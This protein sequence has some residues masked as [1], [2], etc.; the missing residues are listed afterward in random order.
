[1]NHVVD[2]KTSDAQMNDGTEN[3][4]SPAAGAQRAPSAADQAVIDAFSGD[5]QTESDF[6]VRWEPA[7]AQ[8]AERREQR[9][10]EAQRM[11]IVRRAED[12]IAQREK[13][14]AAHEKEVMN[15]SK[16]MDLR[17]FTAQNE[18][19]AI[20]EPAGDRPPPET[21]PEP[22]YIPPA[23]RIEAFAEA[24]EPPRHG[25]KKSAGKKRNRRGDPTLSR[26]ERF[27]RNNI[28][29]RGDSKGE[30]ARK[31]IRIVSFVALV[32]GLVY[33]AFYAFDYYERNR[34]TAAFDE[35]IKSI[36]TLSDQELED[37]WAD[38]RA[39]CPDVDFPEGMQV[40]FSYLYAVNSDFVGWLEIPNTNI[41]TPLVQKANDN[42][43][44]LH[45][46]IH[47]KASRYGTPFIHCL[48]DMSK[49]GL[50]RNTIIFGHNY[51]DGMVFNQLTNYMT[52]EGYLKAPVITMDTLYENIKWK[53]FAVMLTNS[54]P[55]GD[56]G[57]VFDYLYPEFSSDSAFMAKIK[58]IQRRS[59]I[60]TG[61]DVQPTD[62]ILTLYT[63][64]QNIFK[65]GRLVVLARQL[66]P[67]E[68]EAVNAA[69]VY[70]DENAHFPQAYYGNYMEDTEDTEEEAA[71]QVAATTER[72]TASVTETAATSGTAASSVSSDPAP[73]TQASED[74]GEAQSEAAAPDDTGGDEGNETDD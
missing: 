6:R 61:V 34:Q 49:T 22:V 3:P 39:S 55:A 60:H 53:V 18:F 8:A 16:P 40:K 67:G 45:Y 36:E 72:A 43:Y 4:L 2:G 46:D 48:C 74:D 20:S 29:C 56:N 26:G 50:S 69:D 25:G 44:Y 65:G 47:K 10:A 14:T 42:E 54:T 37:L 1:M 7:V 63:C 70:Y 28:P 24:P 41:R 27:R 23:E 62:K 19:E 5:A 32:A 12:S 58:E 71:G 57:Y 59:M 51:R 38:V 21:E 13:K 11:E 35:Q 73:L 68:S 33:L 15:E 64:Y 31:I 17:A 66:R 9:A 52:R 30:I